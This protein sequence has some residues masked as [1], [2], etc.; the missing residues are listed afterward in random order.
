MPNDAL[1]I[2]IF[3]TLAPAISIVDKAIVSNASGV[4]ALVPCLING[5][6]TFFTQP[7]YFVKQPSFLL[8]WGVYGGTYTVAN[9]I[10]VSHT[11]YLPLK[12]MITKIKSTSLFDDQLLD[13]LNYSMISGN[14]REEKDLF[15]APKVC[16]QFLHQCYF[17][18]LERQSICRDVRHRCRTSDVIHLNG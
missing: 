13:N 10:E 3:H 8:I 18:R 4:E 7:L 17:E 1:S 5:V 11:R 15:V 6:K 2:V 12:I 14:L 16:R 9:S